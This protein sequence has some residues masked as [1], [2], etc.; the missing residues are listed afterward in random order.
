MRSALFV[1]PAFAAS[2]MSAEVF[3][4]WRHEIPSGSTSLT[5]Q[6]AD[7]AVVAETCGSLIGALD[8]SNVDKQGAGYLT[9]GDKKFDILSQPTDGGPVCT[10]IYSG[11]IAVVECTGIT[12][13]IP[14][15]AAKSADCFSHE[16]TKAA[17][18]SLKSR[19]D[20]LANATAHV[21]GP[22]MPAFHSRILGERQTTCITNTDVSV[23]GDGNPHQNFLHKQ[24]SVSSYSKKTV[25]D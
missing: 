6:S 15:G 8:F 1:L 25:N 13:D 9:L 23:V 7:K 16:H 22:N 11:E 4:T 24:I 5:I 10:R 18:L 19:S 3:V 17:F 12:L 20:D 14:V 21:E 2:A